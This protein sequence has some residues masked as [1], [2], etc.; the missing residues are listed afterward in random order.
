MVSVAAP[1]TLAA[2]GASAGPGGGRVLPGLILVLLSSAFRIP[3]F[4]NA[5]GLNSDAAAVG[6]QARHLLQGEWSWYQWGAGHQASLESV[7][8]AGA[9]ELFGPTPLV[10]MAVTFLGYL[11]LAILAYGILA[12]RLHPWLAAAA[13]LPL[14]FAPQA[15]N[16]I[17][18]YP[19]RQ[20][21]LTLFFLGAWL[22]DGAGA[23]RRRLPRYALG[24]ALP[25]LAVYLDLYALLLLPVAAAHALLAAR[26]GPAEPREVY[27][28]LAACAGGA[29]AAGALV[30]LLRQAPG[31]ASG[32]AGISLRRLPLNFRLLVDACLPWVLSAKVFVPGAELYPD[33]WNPFW[34]I[35]VV[36]S[37]GAAL[38]L[39]GLALG[40][41][42]LWLRR[43]PWEV[44]R[45]GAVGCLAA[46]VSLGGFLVSAVPVDMWGAR[47]LAPMIWFAPLALAPAA[48]LLGRRWFPP[49][50]APYLASAAVA[51]WL[52]YGPY[53][54]G[55]WPVLSPR[56]AAV[57]EAALGE[58]LRARGV[59]H[60]AAQYWLAYRLTFLWG[61]DPVVV[62]LDPRE[63]RYPPYQ[64]AFRRASTVAYLFHPSEPR[65]RP[66]PVEALLRAQG[67][68][69][70]RIEVAGFTAIL[71]RR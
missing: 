30:L 47:Y 65:A 18:L 4:L 45:L 11:L 29:L 3:P 57:E 61:E 63:D 31:A 12:R 8:A 68:P 39:A 56:G 32:A 60:A 34:W 58:A 13:T 46:G 21:C 42:A 54:R 62:P 20:W 66:E 7:L 6:L 36:Q 71:A 27:R 28:R 55:P 69:H 44:R 17:A 1:D 10:L 19:P 67:I 52:G 33:L 51:G 25:L 49:A 38:L 23:A 16:G 14:V 59:R 35:Q 48:H 70:Q 2:P 50:L 37:A 15:V 53:V 43:L 40:G 9:F 26:D 64:D 5:A 24:A 22:L 41:A